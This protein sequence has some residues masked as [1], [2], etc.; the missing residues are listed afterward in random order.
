MTLKEIQKS[1]FFGS[2]PIRFEIEGEQLPYCL[3]VPRIIPIGVYVYNTFSSIIGEKCQDLW[4]SIQDVPIRCYL[5][6]GVIYDLF[7][8]KGKE[9]N[10]LSISVKRN[11]IPEKTVQRCETEAMS[12]FLFCQ[13][14]KE[15]LFLT[16]QNQALLIENQN[17]HQRILKAV[18]GRKF[19][20]FCELFEPRCTSIN[21]WKL[22]PIKIVKKEGWWTFV[23]KNRTFLRKILE[24]QNMALSLHHKTQTVDSSKG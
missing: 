20:E 10:L 23:K 24:F 14:F 22:L 5:P 17:L 4:F 3:D 13:S 15:S 16:N 7:A 19:D 9:I 12:E 18:V 1:V 6:A 11:S 2:V 8:E 21:E